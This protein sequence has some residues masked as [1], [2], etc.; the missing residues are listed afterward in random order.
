MRNLSI[1]ILVAL[2]LLL[3]GCS[4]NAP[5]IAYKD[6]PAQGDPTRGK[7][8]FNKSVN[9][10]QPCVQCH[11]LDTTNNVG[12]GLGDLPQTAGTR[13]SGE[14]AREYVFNSIVQPSRYIVPGFSNAMYTQ[15]AEKLMP[16]DIADLIAFVLP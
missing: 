13:V 7:E 11:N 6:L 15:Y 9:G 8:L 5:S 16:Q 12:P 1:L 3:F 14:T 2:S 10:A 4:P